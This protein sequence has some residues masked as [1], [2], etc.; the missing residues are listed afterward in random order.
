MYTFY[1]G[2]GIAIPKK[3]EKELWFE[4]IK[5]FLTRPSK[6]YGTQDE[7]EIQ[8]FYV[9]SD[10]SLIIPRFFP[11]EDY[12]NCKIIDKSNEGEMI[13]IEHNIKP[14]NS[15][16]ERAFEYLFH[17]DSGTIEL[18]PGT[19]KTVISIYDVC[20][21]KRKPLILVYLHELSNQWKT[22]FVEHTNLSEDDII[23]VN[24]NNFEKMKDH[25]VLI[26][27]N[28]TFISLLKK[29]PTEFLTEVHNAN[30]GI[31][32]SDECHTSVGA[33]TF[34]QCSINIPAKVVR[35]LSAT[36]YRM[37][38]NDDIIKFHTG[39]IFADESYEGTVTNVNCTFVLVDYGIDQPKRYK[40]LYWGGN[41]N[42]PRYLNLM[43]NPKHCPRFHSVIKGII[44][45]F[46]DKYHSL[47]ILERNKLIDHLYDWVDFENKSRFNRS[48]G[49][50]R[51]NYKLT[52]SSPKK[53]RDGIDAPWKELIV[54]TSPIGNIKQMIGR[55]CRQYEGKEEVKIIDIVDIGCDEI[56]KPMKYR[57]RYYKKNG[58]NINYVGIGLDLNKKYLTEKEADDILGE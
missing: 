4:S 54:L 47:I 2:A 28:Q 6:V 7:I 55:V 10:K 16:Q 58:W 13:D 5:R 9:E 30:I 23:L 12:V 53:M 44:N 3:Y 42:K 56:I 27:T 24:S 8:K 20:I 11:V 26:I 17:N 21:R 45:K 31:F 33:K 57:R 25:K 40:Y 41:F 48:Y 35:G 14:R 32:I 46:K 38:G 15:L 22:R 39:G 43:C 51:L 1:R 37:D 34:S 19:G 52:F 50:D 49:L 29:K 36:P 18:Q